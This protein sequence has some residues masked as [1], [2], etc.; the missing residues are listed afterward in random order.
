[1]SQ[2]FAASSIPAQAF[3]FLEQAPISSFADGSPE[4]AAAAAVYPEALRMVLEVAE[5]SFAS[6]IVQLTEASLLDGDQADD[7]LPYV[8]LLPDDC[9]A[10]R[11]V[12]GLQVSWRRDM[13]YLR[14][15]QPGGLRIRYTALIQNEA[16]LPAT[17]RTAI[18]AQMAVLLAGTYLTTRTKQA[19]LRDVL[20]NA[21]GAALRQD[22][23]MASPQSAYAEDGD[24]WDREATR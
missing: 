20:T 16:R 17:V 9:V 23:R 8:Y 12:Y 24:W 7:D 4:A 6:R 14:C 21:M 13:T 11:H 10:L 18:A 5:W 3:R 15:S 2:P 19:D 22:G 1:M